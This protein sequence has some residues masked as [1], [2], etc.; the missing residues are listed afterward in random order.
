MKETMISIQ[1]PHTDNIFAGIKRVEW[2]TYSLHPGRHHVYETKKGGG[3]GMVIG[4]FK[5]NTYYH[6]LN[7]DDIPDWL[8]RDGCVSREWLKKYARG[9]S[10]FA[11]LIYDVERF[12][13]PKNTI[14][15]MKY[16][17]IH[18]CPYAEDDFYC[19]NHCNYACCVKTPPQSFTYVYIL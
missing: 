6:F 8:I 18:G 15:Y 19:K 14:S 10:L 16:N 12:E 13:H 1:K 3:L 11:N 7:V 17:T 5:T 9:R 4:T 2:R